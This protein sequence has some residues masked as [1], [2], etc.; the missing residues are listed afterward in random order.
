MRLVL[1]IACF[2][3]VMSAQVR[4]T[5]P[6]SHY[7]VREE[8]PATI[9][10]HTHHDIAFCVEY[11]QW[12]QAGKELKST[13]SPF[14]VQQKSANEW[15]VLRIG[16]D[17]GS[18][19]LLLKLDAGKSVEFP[20]RLNDGGTLRLRLDY[21]KS[22]AQPVDCSHANNGRRTSWSKGFLQD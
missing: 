5:L 1:L 10:N 6:K 16:P 20:L 14:V 4:I 19:R 3:S 15:H 12:S 7:R 21:W 8:I 13:P 17:I 11:G 18:N 9:E 22:S 2:A